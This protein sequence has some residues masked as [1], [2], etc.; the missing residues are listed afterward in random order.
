MRPLCP[1]TGNPKRARVEVNE[2]G[3]TALDE[4]GAPV[5]KKRKASTKKADLAKLKERVVKKCWPNKDTWSNR[6]FKD[7]FPYMVLDTCN[8]IIQKEAIAKGFA[9]SGDPFALEVCRAVITAILENKGGITGWGYAGCSGGLGVCGDYLKEIVGRVKSNLTPDEVIT[10]KSWINE[11]WA[12][13]E[14]YGY[15]KGD[16]LDVDTVFNE[17]AEPEQGEA[18]SSRAILADSTSGRQHPVQVHHD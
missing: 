15:D 3:S 6:K 10:H 2:D 14:Q 5:L 7:H 16:L 12:E 18:I 17:E 11:F 8:D 1:G 13:M 4:S 9:A